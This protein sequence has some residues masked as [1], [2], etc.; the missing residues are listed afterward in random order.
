MTPIFFKTTKNNREN[1][2]DIKNIIK[3]RN[4]IYKLT[5]QNMNEFYLDEPFN[6][7]TSFIFSVPILKNWQ[8]K[9]AINN[10]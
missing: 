6:L 8:F 5:K 10:V 7:L 3:K 1:D 4:I 2:I 9:I